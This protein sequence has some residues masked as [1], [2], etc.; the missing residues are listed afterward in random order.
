MKF[1]IRAAQIDLARQIETVETVK[2]FF[3]IAAE[4][5]LNTI[6]MYL[7]DRVKTE[8][9]PYSPDNESY[10]PDQVRELVAHAEKL[11][12]DLIPV[13]SPVGHTERFLRHPELKHLAELRGN[14]PGMFAKG[15]PDDEHMDTCPKL[16]ETLAFFDKYITEVAALFPSKYFHIG[17]D[18]IHEMGFC[19]LCKGTPVV[20][21]FAEAVNHF[22][23]LL[24]G[25]GKEVMIWDDMLE[26]QPQLM[27]MIPKDII[28]CAWF[29]RHTG[30]YPLARFDTS[31]AY[32]YL[33]AY[34]R[35]GFRTLACPWRG[36]SLET[37]TA[38]AAKCNTM[39]MLQTN[40]EMSNHQQLAMLY[41]VLTYA[42]ALW[43]GKELP[44]NEALVKAAAQYTD[45]P[46]AAKALAAA[47][48]S[49][50][51]VGAP[52][53]NKDTKY[54]I[55]IEHNYVMKNQVPLLIEIL[56]KAT[57]RQDVLDAYLLKLRMT[58]V[59]LRLWEIGYE[60]HEFRAGVGALTA[61]EI[62]GKATAM[63]PVVEALAADLYALWDRLRPGIPYTKQLKGE[64]VAITNSVA[65]LVSASET[66]K[67]NEIGRLVVRFDLEEFTAACK[68]RVTVHYADGSTYEAANGNYKALYVQTEKYDY[69]FE[70]PADKAPT[71][72]TLTV[73]GYGAVGFRFVSA[74][75]GGKEYV[76][77]A[78]TA[79]SGQVE[80]AEF[81]LV[82]DSRTSMFNEQEMQQ[83]FRSDISG[84]REHSVTL[85]LREW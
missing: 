6:V 10:S 5:G 25:L 70:I 30:Q 38:Y 57:G 65:W 67:A 43:S 26:Q 55:E 17:F 4:A 1:D 56:S 53:P 50:H 14:I 64:A 36:A 11:G 83:F 76:P 22:H 80:H 32:D 66:A 35:H 20:E 13:V 52:L 42:G 77:A 7:E 45:T 16:P 58:D 81:M 40:W 48:S 74:N 29:Y 71:A 75:V 37:L 33:T 54:P 73:S 2:T 34:E 59:R 51:Y 79:V 18:E 19:E 85:S 28:L 31:R 78:V 46:E 24:V 3:N 27:D 84:K 82:D 47:M 61:A 23:D 39:G 60:L 68:T 44:G 21:I 15:T 9:Y 12:L 72:V 8:T 69:S 62:H 41:P 49:V 63:V